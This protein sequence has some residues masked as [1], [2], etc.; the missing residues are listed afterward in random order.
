MLHMLCSCVMCTRECA[1]TLCQASIQ[2]FV[3]YADCGAHCSLCGALLDAR[4]MCRF[5]KTVRGITAERDETQ[6]AHTPRVLRMFSTWL[7]NENTRML[8]LAYKKKGAHIM[9]YALAHA[10]RETLE[11]ALIFTQKH[12]EVSSE[13]L[14]IVPV[15]AHPKHEKDLGF[16]H[17]K[18][19][20]R[21]LAFLRGCKYK[22]VLLR[23]S[24]RMQKE[25]KLAQRWQNM[26]N[27][28]R[29]KRRIYK[30]MQ[31]IKVIVLFD[32]VITTGATM[33]A[34]HELIQNAL[35]HVLIIGVSIS[36]VDNAV[37]DRTPALQLP[38]LD[39]NQRPNG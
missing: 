8:F 27:A 7:Y 21:Y 17:T 29:L 34:A 2:N 26:Q 37:R 14:C 5:C 18:K 38:R 33:H 15:P 11:E 36:R 10:V 13:N 12:V 32:D 25:L 4:N 9:F 16:S 23:T 19:I 1:G 31:R 20:S 22:S 35:P 39:S 24:S 6:T 30:R 3:S 28:L